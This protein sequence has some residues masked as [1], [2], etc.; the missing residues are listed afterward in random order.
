MTPNLRGNH[1][2][3]LASINTTNL[4]QILL[5][6]EIGRLVD[7]VR[8]DPHKYGDDAVDLLADAL[9]R[10]A[11]ELYWC[12]SVFVCYPEAQLAALLKRRMANGRILSFNHLAWLSLVRKFESRQELSERVFAESMPASV[13]A[14]EV[15]A[16]IPI[17][18][19]RGNRRSE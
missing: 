11:S 6:V 3:I 18:R 17:D 13:L 10:P 16:M 19:S 9:E 14:N 7:G 4:D 2:A 5:R 15:L 12:Q 8:C 1:R